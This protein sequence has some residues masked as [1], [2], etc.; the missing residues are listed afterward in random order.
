[1]DLNWDELRAFLERKFEGVRRGLEDAEGPALHRLQGK[2]AVYRELLRLP[3]VLAG[4][5][6]RAKS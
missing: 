6:E 1:M 5:R 4:E 2:A 3:D